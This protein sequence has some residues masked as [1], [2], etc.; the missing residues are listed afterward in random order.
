MVEKEE[1]K[2]YIEYHPFLDGE[3][4][5]GKEPYT[6]VKTEYDKERGVIVE[7]FKTE[8]KNVFWRKDGKV[9]I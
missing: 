1:F 9:D 2:V 4:P 3:I 5:F 6:L 7:T 8:F